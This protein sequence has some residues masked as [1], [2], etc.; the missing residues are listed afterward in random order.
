MRAVLVAVVLLAAVGTASARIA[1][2][3]REPVVPFSA[4]VPADV[5]ERLAA[6]RVSVTDQPVP[7]GRF[8][9]MRRAV[10]VA[11]SK[12]PACSDPGATSAHL[13]SFVG[14]GV[15]NPPD[16]AW[17]VAERNVCE[18][19]FGPPGGTYD[20]DMA[21]FVDARTGDWLGAVSF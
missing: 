9:G 14:G 8:I 18:W 4:P 17:L 2:P 10:A 20:A 21:T 15:V 19:I 13:V 16:L 1:P 12:T 6:R 11:V 3:E 5:K 7:V